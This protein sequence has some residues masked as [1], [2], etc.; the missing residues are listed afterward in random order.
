MQPTEKTPPNQPEDRDKTAQEGPKD[1]RELTLAQRWAGL[2]PI[3]MMLLLLAFFAYHQLTHTAFF[4]AQ[5]QLP[6]K[7]AL[8]GP[9]LI[10]L[11]APLIRLVKGKTQPVRLLEAVTDLSLGIGAVVLWNHFPFDFSHIADVFPHNMRFAFSWINNNIGRFILILQIVVGFLSGFGHILS[12]MRER[13]E[14]KQPQ[15]DTDKH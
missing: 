1:S 6:E 9:I 7:I 4:N 15:M 2:Y 3:V 12:Y 10:S 14:E 11:A 8:Y 5:F 13:Q